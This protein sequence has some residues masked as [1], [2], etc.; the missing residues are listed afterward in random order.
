MNG[1]ASSF[2]DEI[3]SVQLQQLLQI[4][5]N[6]EPDHND[7]KPENILDQVRTH[8]TDNMTKS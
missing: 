5:H 2:A 6:C 4:W 7:I 3:D 1:D 8:H